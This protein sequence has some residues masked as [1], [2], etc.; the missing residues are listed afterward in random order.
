MD[1]AKRPGRLDT[2]TFFSFAH[3]GTTFGVLWSQVSLCLVS[4]IKRSSLRAPVWALLLV[5]R[6]LVPRQCPCQTLRFTCHGQSYD[7]PGCPKGAP[8]TLHVSRRRTVEG[9]TREEP[10]FVGRGLRVVCLKE[11]ERLDERFMEEDESLNS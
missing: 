2:N 3:V 10:F 11:E 7:C 9:L 6:S 5:E 4:T 1:F 8:Q